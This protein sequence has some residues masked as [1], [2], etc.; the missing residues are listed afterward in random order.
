MTVCLIKDFTPP[1]ASNM[2]KGAITIAVQMRIN[3]VPTFPY[4][5]RRA[6]SEVE[7]LKS[8]LHAAYPKSARKWSRVLG[9]PIGK[10][11]RTRPFGLTLP[12]CTGKT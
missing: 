2:P 9:A 6:I 8:V 4:I 11:V 12:R 5:R 10:M 7:V 1:L 3:C